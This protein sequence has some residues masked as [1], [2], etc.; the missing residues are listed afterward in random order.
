MFKLKRIYEEPA[1]EDGLRV[2]VERLWPRGMSKERAAIALWLREI[3]PS[4]ELRKW[5]RHDP[6]RWE[7]FR[8]RYWEEL[9][10]K[11][12]LVDMLREKDRGKT[13]T[14]VFASRDVDHSGAF[15]L[16]GF[17]E[18]LPAGA[19]TEKKPAGGL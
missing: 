8:R 5:Y 7:E 16:K 2:L 4:T 15:A 12:D 11:K 10:A 9:E 17:M 14:F 3:S 19:A 6:S 13:V 18:K 1:P